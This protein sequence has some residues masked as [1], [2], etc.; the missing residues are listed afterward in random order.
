MHQNRPAHPLKFAPNLQLAMHRMKSCCNRF[1][2]IYWLRIRW[3]SDRPS[4]ATFFSLSNVVNVNG[5]LWIIA[6]FTIVFM[7]FSNFHLLLNVIVNA[8]IALNS[9]PNTWHSSYFHFLYILFD[10]IVL[11]KKISSLNCINTTRLFSSHSALWW[12]V[13]DTVVNVKVKKNI[14]EEK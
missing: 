8:K 14:F 10:F 11:S 4:C 7:F 5:L 3:I 12:C 2:S 9:Q 6:I 1:S 13:N